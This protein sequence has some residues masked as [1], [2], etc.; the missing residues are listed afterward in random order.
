MFKNCD[1]CLID[2]KQLKNLYQSC[3][4]N[5]L[6]AFVHHIHWCC[7]EVLLC[8]FGCL[9]H[10]MGIPSVSIMMHEVIKLLYHAGC[11][12]VIMVRIGT[13]GGLGKVV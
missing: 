7:F 5:I 8:M 12:D 1:F 11:H 3:K 13:C 6:T 4:L 9:Q 2:I 10:G